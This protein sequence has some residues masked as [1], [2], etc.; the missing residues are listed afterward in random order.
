MGGK[1]CL[2][3]S[4]VRSEELGCWSGGRLLSLSLPPPRPPPGPLPGGSRRGSVAAVLWRAARLGARTSSPGGIFRRPPSPQRGSPSG[5]QTKVPVAAAGG[6]GAGASASATAGPA[7]LLP[8]SLPR[9]CWFW[10]GAGEGT[11]DVPG[12]ELASEEGRGIF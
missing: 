4:R 11:L 5:R 1:R 7:A 3:V 10:G 2:P 12:S 8:P 9:A 6:G